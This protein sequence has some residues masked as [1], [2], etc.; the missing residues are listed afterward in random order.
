[1]YTVFQLLC[2]YN[3]CFTNC[4][5]PR[6]I[7]CTFTLL[8]YYYYYYYYYYW[9]IPVPKRSN[10]QVCGCRLTG[11][12]GSNPAEGVDVC[13]LWVLCVVRW[14]SLR[15]ADPSSRGVLPTVMRRYV[16]SRNLKK[17]EVVSRLDRSNK[18]ERYHRHHHP[19]I[20]KAVES[21]S[22]R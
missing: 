17:K 3:L 22:L 5:F 2:S 12:A 1:M 6:W 7:F 10:A 19:H 8:L 11:I 15:R 16:W 9:P 14:R 18:R 20:L 13:L 21:M 4:C